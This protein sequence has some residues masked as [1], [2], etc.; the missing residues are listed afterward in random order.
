LLALFDFNP[1]LALNAFHDAI[2]GAK[3]FLEIQVGL[4]QLGEGH[5]ARHLNDECPRANFQTPKAW[6]KALQKEI[7][8][9][10]MP[11]ATRLGK[12]PEIMQSSAILSDDLF[13]RELEFEARIDRTIEQALDRLEKVKAAKRRVSFREAQRFSRSNPDRLVR[14]VE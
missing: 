1:A 3:S 7:K 8:K 10:L 13:A 12:L 4:D 2:G 9:V 5:F 14:S 6:A 11:A